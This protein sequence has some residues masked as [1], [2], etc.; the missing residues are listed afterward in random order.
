[1]T[2]E[3]SYLMDLFACGVSGTPAHS[4]DG[5]TAWDEVLHLAKEQSI[6]Y[7][8]VYSIKRMTGCSLNKKRQVELFADLQTVAISAFSKR[9]KIMRLLEDFE[10]SGILAVLLKGYTV[11]SLYKS[12]DCRVSDDTDI[13]INK[14][15]EKKAQDFLRGYKFNIAPRTKRSHH[16]VC[17]H[18]EMGL[19]ELHVSLY[20]EIV[21]KIWLHQWRRQNFIK[22]PYEKVVTT[23]GTFYT[24][25]KTDNL[26]YLAFHMTKHFIVSGMSLRMIMDFALFY[27]NN[28][29]TVN[30]SYF[31]QTME[32]LK[33]TY[34]IKIVLRI[35]KDYLKLPINN[36]PDY[37][38]VMT[39]DVEAFLEDLEKGG[40][41]GINDM[42]S[43]LGGW[44][45][46]NR[47]K[48]MSSR[49]K[50]INYIYMLFWNSMGYASA[51]FPARNLLPDR[52]SY[53]KRRVILLPV[54][55]THR[56]FTHEFAH[57]INEKTKSLAFKKESQLDDVAK[58]RLAL[59]RQIQII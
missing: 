22:E 4:R 40:S 35:S 11:A 52:F 42:D 48:L 46:Y 24:L 41:M 25:G 32:Q 28:E 6:Y 15:D 44:P 12:P 49:G 33:Y 19:L 37:T 59:F 18:P 7:T 54:A 16:A 20:G 55:W 45:A 36:I 53:A 21:K 29:D 50:I 38:D 56:L 23:D 26:T 10:T 34:L 2:D 13:Y 47:I 43:R 30:L 27:M 5:F 8:T 57:A 9:L 3:F 39:K 14:K 58:K 1:M 51:L 17:Y 31:W